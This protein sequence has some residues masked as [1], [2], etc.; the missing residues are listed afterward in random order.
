MAGSELVGRKLA[1]GETCF[2]A[3]TQFNEPGAELFTTY[4]PRAAVCDVVVCGDAEA[5]V[6]LEDHCAGQILAIDVAVV[7]KALPADVL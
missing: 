3:R 2:I 1:K 7:A 4:T 6:A 5:L